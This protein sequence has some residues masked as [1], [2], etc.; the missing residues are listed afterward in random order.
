MTRFPARAGQPPGVRRLPRRPPIS[1][2]RRRAV[3]VR[4]DPTGGGGAPPGPARYWRRAP[5]TCTQ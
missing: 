5:N 4:R 2:T 3:A 1:A